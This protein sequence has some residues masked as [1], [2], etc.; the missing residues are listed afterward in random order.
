MQMMLRTKTALAAGFVLAVGVAATAFAQS[1]TPTPSAPSGTDRPA[2]QRFAQQR[3]ERPECGRPHRARKAAGRL[4][5]SESKVQM[6]DGF[7]ILT[8]DRGTI[9]AVNAS[10]K[11]VTIKRADNETVTVT[12]T[13][14]TK[15]CKDGN[16]VALSA[17]KVGDHAGILQSDYEGKHLVRRIGAHSPEAASA[18]PSSRGATPSGAGADDLLPPDLAA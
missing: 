9:T 18:T 13:D 7:A 4:V 8:V 12:A 14:D 1:G 16:A 10:A 2:A 6:E 15:I 11:S 17:L 5:H 3:G